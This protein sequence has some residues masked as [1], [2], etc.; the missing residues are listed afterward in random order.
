MV[1]LREQLHALLSSGHKHHMWSVKC[2]VIAVITTCRGNSQIM[3]SLGTTHPYLCYSW[4]VFVS[5]RRYMGCSLQ[6]FPSG[7]VYDESTKSGNTQAALYLKTL[8]LL[9]PPAWFLLTSFLELI[10]GEIFL[11]TSVSSFRGF[12]LAFGFCFSVLYLELHTEFLISPI[13]ILYFQD[14]LFSTT[15]CHSSMD[16]KRYLM[17]RDFSFSLEADYSIITL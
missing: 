17:F 16:G 8:I 14:S 13:R 6:T 10:L 9:L 11:V 5:L 12:V 1:C 4:L 7:L 3:R 2:Q 15:I